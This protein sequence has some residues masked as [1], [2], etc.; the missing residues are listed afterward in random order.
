MAETERKRM[1]KCEI[2]E[3]IGHGGFEVVYEA[4]GAS[5]RSPHSRR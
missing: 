4:A 3:E 1:G 5:C 2:F